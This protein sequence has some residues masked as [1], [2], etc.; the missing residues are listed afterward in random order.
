MR[1]QMEAKQ[2]TNKGQNT[3]LDAK[4]T[5]KEKM[6]AINLDDDDAI[7]IGK[8]YNLQNCAKN[9]SLNQKSNLINNQFNF[10]EC[11]D[12]IVVLENKI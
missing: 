7:P 5:P 6:D 11:K 4:N 1:M 9:V 8:N 10:N 2:D 3:N 12:E